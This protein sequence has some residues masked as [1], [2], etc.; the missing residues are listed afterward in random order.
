MCSNLNRDGSV[1]VTTQEVKFK[2]ISI[3]QPYILDDK[4]D[5]L[6]YSSSREYELLREWYASQKNPLL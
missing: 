5:Q 3:P 6:N 2:N 4:H 1:N